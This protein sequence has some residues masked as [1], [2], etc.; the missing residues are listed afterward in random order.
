MS[1]FSEQM[2]KLNDILNFKDSIKNHIDT[3]ES[4][5][6]NIDNFLSD[7]E[8]ITVSNKI[9]DRV[10]K[11]AKEALEDKTKATRGFVVYENAQILKL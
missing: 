6:K 1:N 10:Q 9:K 5:W 3:I 7:N 11:E 8:R 2:S 4:I